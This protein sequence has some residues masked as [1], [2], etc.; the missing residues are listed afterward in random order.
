MNKFKNWLKNNKKKATIIGVLLLFLILIFI[1][2]W[3]VIAY[4]IPDTKESVYGDRCEITEDYPI[5]KGKEDKLKKFL[6][7]YEKM[8]LVDFDVKCNLIDIIIEVDDE[9][10]FSDVKSMSKKMLK[11]FTDDELKYYDIELMVKSNKDDS[12]DYPRI[13]THHKEINGSMNEEFIW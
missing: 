2:L 10:S 12:E 8:E 9:T 5:E 6:E 7:D 11:E 13:G 3:G 4:L 1:F